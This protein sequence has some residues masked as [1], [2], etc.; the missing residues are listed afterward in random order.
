MFDPKTIDISKVT[1]TTLESPG[2]KFIDRKLISIDEIEILPIKDNPT[3]STGKSLTQ[4]QKLEIS[5]RD[6]GIDY[7]QM[8]PVVRLLPKSKFEDGNLIKYSLVAGNHR[9]E[10]LR[11]LG[12]SEWVFDIYEIPNGTK[13]SLEEALRTFQLKENNH[14]PAMG[15]KEGDVVKTIISLVFANSS[16]VSAD[17]TSILAYINENCSKLHYNTKAK[18][19]KDVI[20]GLQAN[21]AMPMSDVITYTPQDV[22]DFMYR[23]TDRSWNG[24]HDET[25]DQY[26][27][28]MLQ[29]YEERSVMNALRRYDETGKISYFS[30]HTQSPTENSSL[31]ERREKM[32]DLTNDIGL[33][34]L[35]AAAY[36]KKHGTLPWYVAGFLPQDVASGEKEF[37]EVV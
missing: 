32:V 10:A 31:F 2:V 28:T 22:Q 16:L 37:I 24:H 25:R 8:P 1:F 4:I 30:L 33:A 23:K 26:G 20:R 21:G 36:Y 15:V 6:D 34:I 3:R 17:E 29:G 13:Y 14:S 7:N 35:K 27:F 12:F 5:F 9:L 11:R 19:V 18:I